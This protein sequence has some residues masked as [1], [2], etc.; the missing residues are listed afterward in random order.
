MGEDY[1]QQGMYFCMIVYVRL[2]LCVRMCV[3]VF[4]TSVICEGQQ[5]Y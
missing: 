5:G 2:C 3:S 1:G 4:A